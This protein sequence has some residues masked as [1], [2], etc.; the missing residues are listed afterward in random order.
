MGGSSDRP[1]SAGM[2]TRPSGVGLSLP[3]TG[4]RPSR[5]D[6]DIPEHSTQLGDSF[7][8]SPPSVT[9]RL[10][11]DLTPPA[12]PSRVGITLQSP[13]RPSRVGMDLPAPARPSRVGIDLPGASSRSS[14][15]PGESTGRQRGFVFQPSPSHV[16]RQPDR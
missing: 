11:M 9:S 1:N 15:A 3:V 13:A 16:P 10:T 2:N 12:R 8:Q 6:S 5:V 7:T 14:S 4:P